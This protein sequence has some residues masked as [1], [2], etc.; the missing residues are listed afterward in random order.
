MEI[1]E[2]IDRALKAALIGSAAA[3]ALLHGYIE[4]FTDKGHGFMEVPVSEAPHLID[5]ETVS[6]RI[7]PGQPTE[8]IVGS[9]EE[10]TSGATPI[11]T[12]KFADAPYARLFD[13]DRAAAETDTDALNGLRTTLEEL[14]ASGWTNLE[15]RVRGSASAEDDAQSEDAGLMTSNDKNIRLADARRDAFIDALEETL[16][17]DNAFA[18]TK[19]PGVEDS[20]SV[21]E[22]AGV[23]RMAERFNYAS[24]RDMVQTWQDTP[25]QVPPVVASSL[26]ILLDN[27]RGVYVEIYGE[28]PGTPTTLPSKETKLVCAIPIRETTRNEYTLKSWDM[29]VPYVLPLM[30]T[31]STL[32]VA[33]AAATAGAHSQR[34][35]R[36]HTRIA[37][38]GPYVQ[39]RQATKRSLRFPGTGLGDITPSVPPIPGKKRP[40]RTPKP[41]KPPVG[42]SEIPLVDTIT[43]PPYVPEKT[44]LGCAL[45]ALKGAGIGIIFATASVG[46]L[47]ACEN[48]AP[49]PKRAPE[50]APAT[51]PCR[52]LPEHEYVAEVNEVK[53]IDGVV[54]KR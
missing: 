51:D 28:Q 8:I 31:G 5:T 46:L 42:S 49:T 26:A 22:F 18:V 37:D 45:T 14:T 29:T 41:P 19:E 36:S 10:S 38:S 40:P 48:D 35:R 16:P 13:Q 20:L 25:D 15:L 3:S 44:R 23:E 27:E 34:R 4:G 53:V 2:R 52:D 47:K 11:T 43:D 32:A 24:V 9:G 30:L 1:G 50:A 21:E 39:T 12:L 17:Q 33:G 6:E 7:G 54:S